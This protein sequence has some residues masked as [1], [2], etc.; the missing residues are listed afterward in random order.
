[1]SYIHDTGNALYAYIL[2]Y[3][4]IKKTLTNVIQD[5]IEIEREARGHKNLM[6]SH[7][8]CLCTYST[9]QEGGDLEGVREEGGENVLQEPLQPTL[10]SHCPREAMQARSTNSPQRPGE[11]RAAGGGGGG[12]AHSRAGVWV[13]GDGAGVADES[14]AEQLRRKSRAARRFGTH[15]RPCLLHTLFVSL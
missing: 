15:L 13:R 8:A 7:T 1:M 12:S 5:M 11:G 10:A 9:V 4:F 14:G 6:S 2:K 3:Y